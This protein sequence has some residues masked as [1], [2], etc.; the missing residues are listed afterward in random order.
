MTLSGGI[1][2]SHLNNPIAE[3]KQPGI[4][5]EARFRLVARKNCFGTQELKKSPFR[6]P[7]F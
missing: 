6:I 1:V 5:A 3:R 2:T 4:P 7:G